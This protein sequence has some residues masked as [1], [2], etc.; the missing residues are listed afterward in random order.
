ML[1]VQAGELYRVKEEY[2]YREGKV[3]RAGELHLV[4]HSYG[5]I[6]HTMSSGRLHTWYIYDFLSYAERV[7]EGS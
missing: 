2:S 4:T 3:L 6:M 1:S 7:E 5:Q